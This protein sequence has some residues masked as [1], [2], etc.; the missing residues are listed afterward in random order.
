MSPGL[1]RAI[2]WAGSRNLLA[3][4]VGVWPN[5]VI[6]WQVHG[7]PA[8]RCVELER[9]TGFPRHTFNPEIFGRP[10]RRAAGR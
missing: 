1:K 7:V 4:R 2:A 8:Q 5:A 3:K 10:P 9:I 6:Y